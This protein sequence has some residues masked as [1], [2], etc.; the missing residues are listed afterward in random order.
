MACSPLA[1]CSTAGAA[2]WPNVYTRKHVARLC[3]CARSY[4]AGGQ[5]DPSC[6]LWR[7]DCTIG[8]QFKA[9]STVHP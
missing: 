1:A 5:V 9:L 3:S 7:L 6:V 8:Q 2:L 4:M